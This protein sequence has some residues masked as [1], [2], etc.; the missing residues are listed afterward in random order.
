MAEISPALR[1][2][3]EEVARPDMAAVDVGCGSGRM[4]FFLAPLVREVVGVDVS[5]AVLAEARAEAER[6]GVRT[7]RFVPGDA[8]AMDY[9]TLFS[10][11]RVD[12]VTAH[13]CLSDAVIRRAAEALRPGGVFA[14]AGLEQAQ[15]M[16]TGRR[17]RFAYAPEELRRELE[18]A[19]FVVEHLCLEREVFGFDTPEELLEDYLSDHPRRKQWQRDGRWEGLQRYLAEGGR[20]F[21]RKSHLIG[22]ARRANP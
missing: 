11:G 10:E 3:I 4:T 1:K 16:E 12:L 13:L 7:V 14:F 2:W 18:A 5:E 15:A 9:R 17:S 21:T 6:Q 20:T 8:E 22:R 19:G